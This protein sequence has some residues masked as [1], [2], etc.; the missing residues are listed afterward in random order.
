MPVPTHGRYLEELVL[1]F[2]E[3]TM[4]P[5]KLDDDAAKTPG[6]SQDGHSR[7]PSSRLIFGAAQISRFSS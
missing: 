5:I 3:P 7:H 2:P 6:E 1:C 4:E